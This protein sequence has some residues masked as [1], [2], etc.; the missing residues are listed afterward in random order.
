VKHSFPT[1][2]T[3]PEGST[4]ASESDTSAP[5]EV[6]GTTTLVEAMDVDDGSAPK[7]MEASS[8]PHPVVTKHQEVSSA[9]EGLVEPEHG[10]DVDLPA[11]EALAV[12]LQDKSDNPFSLKGIPKLEEFIPKEYFPDFLLVYDPKGVT[13]S[14][15]RRPESKS[16]DSETQPQSPP[17]PRKYKRLY[18]QF[19]DSTPSSSSDE[20]ASRV[21]SLYFQNKSSSRIGTGNH[22]AVWR[23]SLR[24]PHP[25]TARSRNGHVSVAAKLAFSFK[26]DR[27]LLDNEGKMYGAFPEHLM[28]EWCG[29]N[30][31]TPLRHP[32]PVGAVVPKFYGY[33]VP[34][35]GPEVMAEEVKRKH[36]Y[37][38][39]DYTAV[40]DDSPILLLEECGTDIIPEKLSDDER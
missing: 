34:V 11:A 23:A 20:N 6:T 31:V 12:P 25:L 3:T 18:P 9:V 1:Y 15:N 39:D 7:E 30:L 4:S 28:E 40:A 36:C 35:A 37:D 21:A 2:P 19:P 14:D 17:T 32:V 24:L 10:M 26:G 38:Y 27:E 29:Y 22:S 13:L 33:Y 16:K 8:V 5:A